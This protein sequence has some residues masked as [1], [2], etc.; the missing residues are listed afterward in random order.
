MAF[1]Y[2]VAILACFISILN[3][4]IDQWRPYMLTEHDEFDADDQVMDESPSVVILWQIAN[5]LPALHQLSE[6]T[7]FELRWD[8]MEYRYQN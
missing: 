4:Y 7:H 8:L 2:R 3:S 5:G 6:D 1:F